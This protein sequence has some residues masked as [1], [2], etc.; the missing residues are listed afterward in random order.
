V[1]RTIS[2]GSAFDLSIAAQLAANIL[3]SPQRCQAR[4]TAGGKV[5]SARSSTKAVFLPQ[6]LLPWA[7]SALASQS[8]QAALLLSS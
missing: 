8:L 7:I 6:W 2:I 3:A 1:R 5:T 4:L